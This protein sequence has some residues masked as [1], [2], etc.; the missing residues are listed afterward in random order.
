MIKNGTSEKPGFLQNCTLFLLG[1]NIVLIFTERTIIE[2][3]NVFHN[4]IYNLLSTFENPR[5]VLTD[6]KNYYGRH[7]NC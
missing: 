5:A 2:M 1:T 3:F 6:M 7:I 4:G